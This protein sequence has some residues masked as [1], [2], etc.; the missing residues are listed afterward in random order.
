MP[1][2][3]LDT[4]LVSGLVKE[5]LGDV[6]LQA[7]RTLLRRRKAGAIELC[8]SAVTAEELARLPDSARARHEDIY[9]LLEDVPATAE[10][11][12]STMLLMGVGGPHEDPR[13]TELKR[14]VP[15][16]SDARHLFQAVSN[17]I[18]YFVTADQRTIGRH[19]RELEKR[20]GIKVRLPSDLIAEI[21]GA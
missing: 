19:A 13:L 18:S 11:S 10:R 17:G 1:S 8:T 9:A 15:D 7:L 12:G 21:G 20:L 16:E 2:G 6:E 4:N 3:Y 5:D 14:I